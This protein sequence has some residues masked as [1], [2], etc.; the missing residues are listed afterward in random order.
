MV[1]QTGKDAEEAPSPVWVFKVV[2]LGD[3]AVGKTCIVQRYM[4]NRFLANYKASIGTDISS[5]ELE[6]EGNRVRLQ[7]WDMSGQE[8]FR[9][10]RRQYVAGTDCAIIVFD[11]TRRDSLEHVP[12]WV[13]EA[14]AAGR[15]PPMV[16]VGN[17][18]DMTAEREISRE[19]AEAMAR[20]H[21][22]LFYL[23]TSAK[24]G[25]NIAPLFLEVA[26]RTLEMQRQRR[27]NAGRDADGTKR[28]EVDG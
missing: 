4:T 19:D 11:L 3:F 10:L 15:R 13:E 14:E 27:A 20:E 22:M 8:G 9:R 2:M 17:K 7:I 12:R 28:E 5:R 25:E 21:G 6:L 23:E 16:L 1:S 24:S 26:R 18:S